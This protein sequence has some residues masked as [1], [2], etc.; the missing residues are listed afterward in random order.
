MKFFDGGVAMFFVLLLAA[1]SAS[2]V[3]IGRCP[4]TGKDLEDKL[5]TAR[6][7]LLGARAEATS[8][9]AKPTALNTVLLDRLSFE[10]SY[11]NTSTVIL[12]EEARS[13]EFKRGD[14]KISSAIKYTLPFNVF[15]RPSTSAR[16]ANKELQDFELN[17][18]R[19]AFYDLLYDLRLALAEKRVV[20]KSED[21][22]LEDVAAE[23]KISKL[24]ARVMN[25]TNKKIVFEPECIQ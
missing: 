15:S 16:Q 17:E 7:I 12:H 10:A 14:S 3:E 24:A 8:E 13:Y 22:G 11:G 18:Q 25:M 19:V 9:A 21:K 5:W 2:A 4:G 20:E 23:V 1:H 6:A